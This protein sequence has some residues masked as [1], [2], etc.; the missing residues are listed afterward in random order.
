M[1]VDDTPG[2]VP[3]TTPTRDHTD[4][5]VYSTT[6]PLHTQRHQSKRTHYTGLF[7]CQNTTSDH[8]IMYVT[9]K[10]W[11]LVLTVLFHT[12]TIKIVFKI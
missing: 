12:F 8:L 2:S 6:E 5:G 11:S 1:S 9:V 10:I 3:S 7:S 4:T